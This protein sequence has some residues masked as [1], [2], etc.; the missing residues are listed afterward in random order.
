MKA[1]KGHGGLGL[2]IGHGTRTRLGW[3]RFKEVEERARG[4]ALLLPPMCCSDLFPKSRTG[5]LNEM[6]L[7]YVDWARNSSLKR[8]RQVLPLAQPRARHIMLGCSCVACCALSSRPS[9]HL[10]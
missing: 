8:D 2:S 10:K 5:R 7:K 9:I 1:V 3:S 6:K 4:R